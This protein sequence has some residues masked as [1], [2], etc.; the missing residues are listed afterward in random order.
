MPFLVPQF[1]SAVDISKFGKTG[2]RLMIGHEKEGD[3]E[4]HLKQIQSVTDV[5]YLYWNAAVTADEG[6]RVQRRDYYL[7]LILDF[8]KEIQFGGIDKYRVGNSLQDLRLS[9]KGYRFHHWVKENYGS[10]PWF[11]GLWLRRNLQLK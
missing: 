4:G 7:W 2:I 3:T 5:E 8:D 1:L 11:A 10:S 6:N 9:L